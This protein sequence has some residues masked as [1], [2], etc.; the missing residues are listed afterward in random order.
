MSATYAL[1]AKSKGF[2]G[3]VQFLR[4]SH[5]YG[6]RKYRSWRDSTRAQHDCK[7]A[8]ARGAQLRELRVQGFNFDRG[9]MDR[10]HR[11]L[12]KK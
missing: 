9:D 1:I 3:S 5:E 8:K 6:M 4:G 10:D 11:I 12:V 7:G 2:T